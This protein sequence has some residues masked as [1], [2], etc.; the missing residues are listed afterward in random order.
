MTFTIHSP[1]I[2]GI[3]LAMVLH[4]SGV[5]LFLVWRLHALDGRHA[6]LVKESDMQG[7]AL[8]EALAEIDRYRRPRR[9]GR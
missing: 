9:Q 6:E 1:F 3:L 2:M 8:R 5:A 4:Q 7:D